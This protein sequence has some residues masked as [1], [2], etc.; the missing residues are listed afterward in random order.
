MESPSLEKE[1]IIKQ[2]RNLFEFEKLKKKRPLNTTMKDIR[3]LFRLKIENKSTR[4]IMLINI[5]NIFENE[6]E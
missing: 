4:D 1:N 3:N 6:R 2:I 5:R